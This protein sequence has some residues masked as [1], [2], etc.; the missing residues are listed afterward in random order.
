MWQRKR[1][2]KGVQMQGLKTKPC[3]LCGGNSHTTMQCF[4]QPRK[5]MK[6]SKPMKPQG[7]IGKKLSAQSQQWRKDNPPNHEGFYICY[8]CDKWITPEEMDVEHT[9]SKARNPQH[10]FT[11]ELLKPSCGTCN[12]LKGSKDN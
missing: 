3:K 9:K 1:Q 7:K 4:L 11:K 2:A 8:M 10:R 12:A 6:P 5:Q